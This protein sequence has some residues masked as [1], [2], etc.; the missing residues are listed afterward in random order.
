MH[1][2]FSVKYWLNTESDSIEAPANEEDDLYIF[3]TGI[4]GVKSIF[5]INEQKQ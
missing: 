4:Y 3:N 1:I 5:Y 2:T